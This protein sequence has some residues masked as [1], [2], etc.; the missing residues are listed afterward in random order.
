MKKDT[1]ENQIF[2]NSYK[3]TAAREGFALDK[4]EDY[5]YTVPVTGT[6]YLGV[7][8]LKADDGQLKNYMTTNQFY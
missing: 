4:N 1:S 8:K 5:I 6:S 2:L 3:L 7:V